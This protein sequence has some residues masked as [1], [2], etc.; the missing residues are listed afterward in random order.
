[1]DIVIEGNRI[2]DGAPGRLARA[3][4]QPNR[5]PR[6]AD[7]EIDGK[8]MYVMP[9]FVDMHVHG[10]A[11]DKA[12]DLSY[13]YKLWLAH[14]VTTVRGVSLSSAAV[15][16]SEKDRSARERDRRAAHLQLPDARLGMA[17]RSGDD[18]GEG[19]RVGPLGRRQQH[20]RHQV[21][22]PRRRDGDHHGG[23]RR[24]AQEQDGHRRPPSQTACQ[25]HGRNAGD[26]APR[27]HHPL[28]RPHG[29]A[30]EGQDHPGVPDWLRLQQRAGPLRRHRPHLEPDLR[31]RLTA[32]DRVPRA[33]EG[34][35]GHLRSDVQ[36]LRAVAI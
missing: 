16:S 24:S 1:M 29:V 35:Q 28:L 12:P 27:H 4:E 34:Q 15:S 21:L 6:D 25:L 14:G 33:P 3:A 7:H 36:H 5:E 13:A 22:Q 8:G 9:G 18:A 31:A 19:A 11:R 20:R 26:G 10:S 2:T 32:V 23:N 17:E 30:P